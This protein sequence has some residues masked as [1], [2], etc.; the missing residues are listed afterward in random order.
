MGKFTAPIGAAIL[1]NAPD[2]VVRP[3]GRL[4]A[5]MDAEVVR[6]HNGV[7]PGGIISGGI[8]AP[9]S[10]A[11]GESSQVWG[12]RVGIWPEQ[13]GATPGDSFSEDALQAAIDALGGAGSGNRLYIGDSFKLA[14]GSLRLLNKSNIEI[15]GPGELVLDAGADDVCALFYLEG[16]CSNIRYT[17]LR[18][19]G[20]GRGDVD[21]RQTGI[22]NFSGQTINGVWVTSCTIENLN[23]GIVFNAESGGTFTNGFAIDNVIKNMKGQLGGQGY[24]LFASG[25]KNVQFRGGSI[26]NAERHS[27]YISKLGDVATD[28]VGNIVQG[29]VIRGHRATVAPDLGRSAIF[30]GRG[31]GVKICDN[32]II[33]YYGGAFSSGQDTGGGGAPVRN[34][35][36][37]EYYNNT[38]IG[39]RDVISSVVLSE[40][41]VPT[42]ATSQR[43][44]LK[45]NK[46]V[47][48]RAVAP[49]QLEIDIANGKYITI[50]R[51]EFHFLNVPNGDG[52]RVIG[53]GSQAGAGDID[54]I[55]IEEN[56]LTGS[57]G[58]TFGTTP[59]N[60]VY[61][62]PNQCSGTG[63][64]VVAN[65]KNDTPFLYTNIEAAA[66]L[67]NKN[68]VNQMPNIP[69]TG[70]YTAGDTTPSVAHG[71][72]ALVIANAAATV[73]TTLDDGVEGQEVTLCF[74]DANTTLDYGTFR[75][76]ATGDD[77]VS[78]LYR[79]VKVKLIVGSWVVIHEMYTAG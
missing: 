1:G 8:K 34:N 77:L 36:D 78:A 33:D 55:R 41:L 42:T 63:K 76:T 7:T 70:I 14:N 17:G 64:I 4:V 66:T 6:L 3:A 67:T 73:I 13:F 5:D 11:I 45:G 12:Q 25:A 69:V 16:I 44:T 28:P 46:Y 35:G 71:V 20:P 18:L 31:F 49:E 27:V 79:T 72:Q 56:R 9:G 51:E 24:G 19:R 68:V 40:P 22:G 58:G 53:V 39:R 54:Y 61:L 62:Y 32:Q 15:Y 47:I 59:C 48:D 65:N 50:D 60:F 37:I 57:G 23:Q 38:M 52:F 10:S 75:T 74:R 26:T 43:V 2:E 29:I 30:A 21:A